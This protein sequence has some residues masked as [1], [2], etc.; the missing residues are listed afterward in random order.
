MAEKIIEKN[1]F[2]EIKKSYSER[3]PVKMIV[4]DKNGDIIFGSSCCKREK[5]AARCNSWR[6]Q[7]IE[8]AARWGE[9]TICACPGKHLL[10]AVPIMVNSIVTGGIIACAQER[11]VIPPEDGKA[12]FNVR[13]AC[14]ELRIMAEEKN[15]TNASY[16]AL[17]RQ[18]YNRE[19]KKA[20]ILHNLKKPFYGTIRDIYLREEPSVISAIRRGDRLEARKSINN[21][22]LAIY[23]TGHGQLVLLKSLLM[24]LVV[25]M[26]RT[27][28]EMGGD[29]ETLLGANY[30]S[31]SDL[32]KFET[33]E[34][35]GRWLVDILEKIMDSIRRN[36]RK[37]S[38]SIGL[39]LQ[40]MRENFA[41]DITRKE[42]AQ[43]CHLS[44]SHFSRTFKKNTGSSFS[45]VLMQIRINHA[46]ELLLNTDLPLMQIAFS[47]GFNDQ[48]Y[49]CK[50]FRELMGV[51]PKT[52]RK[53]NSA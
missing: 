3:W 36:R 39:A 24:E 27:A 5:K 22:L 4:T 32:S 35:I 49:F 34:E 14:S 48:S 17:R 53:Q 6:K 38:T 50:A 45:E 46:A 26:Y 42:A 52:Y 12:I 29:T 41:K 1:I 51:T 13:K 2:E 31:I 44:E 20:Y 43:S 40:F 30:E 7:T 33:E 28:V 10:W 23:T 15:L 9:P 8:E 37:G 21:I 19:Q 16:L 47:S 11:K 25:S 18:E